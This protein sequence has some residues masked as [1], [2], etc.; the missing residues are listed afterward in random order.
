MKKINPVI[1]WSCYH[2]RHRTNNAKE[3]W[4]NKVNSYI[5]RPHP[6]IKNALRC[7]Q[8]AENWNYLYMRMILNLESKKERSAMLT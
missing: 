5:E 8:K 7:L 6:N 1:L 2:R 4:N 3:G